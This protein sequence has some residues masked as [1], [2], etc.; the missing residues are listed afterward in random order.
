MSREAVITQLIRYRK[1]E[2]NLQDECRKICTWMCKT[3]GPIHA[4]VTEGHAM[5]FRDSLDSIFS[6]CRLH[7]VQASELVAPDNALKVNTLEERDPE[8]LNTPRQ[9]NT[10]GTAMNVPIAMPRKI[11][12]EEPLAKRRKTEHRFPESG[13]A[14]F[15]EPAKRLPRD[16]PQKQRTSN[17][18]KIFLEDDRQQATVIG[19]AGMQYTVFAHKDEDSSS[20][21][22]PRSFTL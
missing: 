4:F 15:P 6:T 13:R 2:E 21:L 16:D 19:Q 7:P 11:G 8:P 12:L 18:R 1:I 17:G 9:Q 3:Y 14:F 22:P 5:A 10:G 20:L